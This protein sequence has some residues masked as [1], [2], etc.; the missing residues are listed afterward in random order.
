MEG[1]IRLPEFAN[2]NRKRQRGQEE[3]IIKEIED[4]QDQQDTRSANNAFVTTFQRSRH[5]IRP[6]VV[7]SAKNFL[8]TRLNEEQSKLIT[9]II[10]ITSSR[11]AEELINAAIPLLPIGNIDNTQE[12]IDSV[13]ENFEWMAPNSH[14]PHKDY[15]VRLFCMLKGSKRPVTKLLSCFCVLCPHSMTVEECVSTYNMTFSNLRMTASEDTLNSCLMI[16]WNGAPTASFGPKP[17]EHAFLTKKERRMNLR[18]LDS[19]CEREF[20]KKFFN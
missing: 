12:F 4:N 5:A 16:H 8:Q 7:Q 15:G 20:I 1:I 17:V 19:Y 13:F 2:R 11:N 14:I 9:N 3:K 18:R 10:A 6:E